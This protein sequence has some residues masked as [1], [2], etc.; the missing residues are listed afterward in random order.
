MHADGPRGQS[1]C[2]SFLMFPAGFGLEPCCQGAGAP[3]GAGRMVAVPTAMLQPEEIKAKSWR[4]LRLMVPSYM[5]EMRHPHIFANLR[6]NCVSEMR[7]GKGGW[8]QTKGWLCRWSM[9]P[10]SGIMGL[11]EMLPGGGMFGKGPSWLVLHGFAWHECSTL[12]W[13]ICTGFGAP[14]HGLG[15]AL[16]VSLL[17]F[18]HGWEQSGETKVDLVHLEMGSPLTWHRAGCCWE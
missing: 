9:G 15:S 5:D 17:F 12:A 13:D 16:K 14:E 10:V 7:G 8:M 11:A 1:N 3:A 2:I 4:V 6:L 18:G